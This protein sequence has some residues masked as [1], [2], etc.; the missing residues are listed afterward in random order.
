MR[1]V[2]KY[3]TNPNETRLQDM[4]QPIIGN[5]DVLVKVVYFL[6]AIFRL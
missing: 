1:T 3:G 2:I 4:P 5:E 6:L